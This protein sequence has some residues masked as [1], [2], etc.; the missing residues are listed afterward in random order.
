MLGTAP[1][2]AKWMVFRRTREDPT[3]PRRLRKLSV[4]K[5][6]SSVAPNSLVDFDNHHRLSL[7]RPP[8]T[9]I[10]KTSLEF[11]IAMADDTNL[12][13]NTSIFTSILCRDSPIPVPWISGLL[14][15]DP[16]ASSAVSPK[17]ALPKNLTISTS[18][19]SCS[20]T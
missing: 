13:L 10:L 1:W 3:R 17:A 15:S 8:W 20:D 18:S 9:H 2:G 14:W 5:P 19:C 6:A 11:L 7:S 16:L 4:A 12:L